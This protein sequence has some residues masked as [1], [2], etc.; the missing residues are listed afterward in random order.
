MDKLSLMRSYRAVVESG[1]FTAAGRR[2]GR[3]KAMISRQINELESDLSV[4][5]INR[6][7]RKLNVTETGQ[8]YYQQCCRILDDL[9][10]VERS[11]QS[12]HQAAKGLLRI[13]APHTF[14]ELCLLDVINEFVARYPEVK[15]ELSLNDRF[16]DIVEEGFDLGL[17]IA[18]LEDMSLIARKLSEIRIIVCASPEYLR[19]H[20]RP[21]SPEDL[22]EHVC[23]I[24]SNIATKQV[25][26]FNEDKHVSVQGVLQANSAVAI[27]KAVRAGIGIGRCPSFAVASD[28][29]EGR[30]IPLLEQYEPEPRGVYAIYPHRKHLAAKVRLFVE[31]LMA[32]FKAETL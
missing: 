13:N 24:D 32:Y 11:L 28:I 27:A 20:K 17:R 10:D 19:K 22:Q 2:M 16:V 31:H 23:V 29:A 7:T 30:L 8:A 4:R 25:W 1:S 15:I 12:S 26:V 3:T 14:A 6:T 9:D 18:H 5:L 21:L